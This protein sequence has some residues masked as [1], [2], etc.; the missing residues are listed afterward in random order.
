[1]STTRPGLVGATAFRIVTINLHLGYG[2]DYNLAAP[3]IEECDV[4]ETDPE[5]RAPP[6]RQRHHACL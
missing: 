2:F 6:E 1:M 4:D 3:R 5:A